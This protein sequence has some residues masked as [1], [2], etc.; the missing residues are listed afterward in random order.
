MQRPV[1]VKTFVFFAALAAPALIHF[2]L[3]YRYSVNAPRLDDFSEVLTFL[4]NFYEANTWHEKIRIFFAVYQDHRYGVTHVINLITDGINFRHY[5]LWGN[6]LIPAY[7]FLVWKSLQQHPLQKEITCIAAL[8]FFNLQTWYGTYW[9]SI[10]LTSLGSLP[11]ALG[12]FL[13]ACSSKRHALP[14]ALFSA[15]ALTYTLGNGIFAWPL[16]LVYALIDNKH[17]ALPLWN[18]RSICWLLIGGSILWFYFH[19]FQ[20]LNR[21]G[22]HGAGFFDLITRAIQN[23][24]NI[25]IGFFSL[26]GSH[27]LYYSQQTDWRIWVSCFIGISETLALLWLLKQGALRNRPALLLLLAFTVLTMASIALARAATINLGQ[28]LQGHYKLY[29]A[30]YLLL[31]IAALLDLLAQKKPHHTKSVYA[32]CLGG[33][34]T[35]F[36]AALF[37]FVRT[38]EQYNQN[39]AVDA[40]Q[41][42][43]SNT[44]QLGE[45]RL[46]VKQP[47]KK[48][49]RAVQG[50][51]YNPWTLLNN[52]EI[53]VDIIYSQTCPPA[54]PITTN[55]QSHP[56]AL[57]VKLDLP[58]TDTSTKFCL[59]GEK[60]AIYF[61]PNAENNNPENKKEKPNFSLWI[62]RNGEAGEDKG[63]WT[64]YALP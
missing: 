7:I 57:A 49:A 2:Y 31:L 16:I 27:L 28:T 17:K 22:Q 1:S 18:A 61:T 34:I 36:L 4:P 29:P 44:L 62:P 54:T 12:T 8:L 11:I 48:L 56:H 30:T 32:A 3:L 45:T 10:L 58:T 52:D 53:P 23:A 63:P 40:K 42:L 19:D 5:V 21:E 33:V 39:L 38:V 35:L 15:I 20:F 6:L 55:T 37:L 60:Q 9:A 50:N 26:A 43:Y 24:P 14:L 59:Q 41:W 64:L 51:F 13:L 46:Y 25:A 47:N